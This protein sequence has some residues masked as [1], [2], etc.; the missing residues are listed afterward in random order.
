[1]KSDARAAI[2]AC[3][4][5]AALTQRRFGLGADRV[6]YASAGDRARA[7]ATLRELE[8]RGSRVRVALA[9]RARYL[10][11]GNRDSAF[12]WLDSA[13]ATR[14]PF[15][16]TS[17]SGPLFDPVRADPALADCVHGWG[18]NPDWTHR[19]SMGPDIFR[20]LMQFFRDTWPE[21]SDRC[22]SHRAGL[23]LYTGT[24]LAAS[25][26]GRTE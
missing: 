19:L 1:M 15:L 5:V 14:D 25:R 18:C 13:Y 2:T 4:R 11:L 24:G 23:G 17:I 7:T 10:G 16:P 6:A 12:A 26:G 9:G 21:H 3:E 8:A 20:Q 22:E